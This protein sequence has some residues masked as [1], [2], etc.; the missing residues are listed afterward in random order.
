MVDSVGNAKP[1]RKHPE[2]RD[3]AFF[4]CDEFVIEPA[5]SRGFKGEIEIHRG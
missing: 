4:L 1:E 5:E 3:V 2:A